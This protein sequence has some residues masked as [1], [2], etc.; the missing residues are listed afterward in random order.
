G[1]IAALAIL[2][3][4]KG[5]THAALGLLLGAALTARSGGGPWSASLGVGLGA[6]GAVTLAG[7]VM[8]AVG[9]I[10]QRRPAAWR[11]ARWVAAAGVWFA[12]GFRVAA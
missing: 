10:L 5:R 6:V 2:V 1:I 9:R 3:A 7:P 11:V 8:V 12:V 4:G